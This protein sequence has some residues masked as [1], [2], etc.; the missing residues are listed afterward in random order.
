MLTRLAA[1]P[2]LLL[3]VLL[4]VSNCH[5][6]QSNS[7]SFP[8]SLLASS[9]SFLLRRSSISL[10]SPPSFFFLPSSSPLSP[11]VLFAKH[12][13]KK[14]IKGVMDTR[15]RKSRPSDK[16]R[17]PPNYPEDPCKD[18]PDITP[19]SATPEEKAR[20]RSILDKC[21]FI[22]LESPPP[23]WRGFEGNRENN[24]MSRIVDAF[25]DEGVEEK[26]DPFVELVDNGPIA[27]AAR[28]AASSK[29]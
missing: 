9:R 5:S 19:L 7:A 29:T 1:L 16:N 11:T 24:G 10:Y 2:L 14:A 27:T 12:A 28:A 26:E 18:L 20:V 17:R 3:L 4:L 21:D 6:W 13:Q 15:P 22:E 25:A 8:T 23:G